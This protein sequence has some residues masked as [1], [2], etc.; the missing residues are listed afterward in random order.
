MALPEP[1]LMRARVVFELPAISVRTPDQDDAF[2]AAVQEEFPTLVARQMLPLG[3]PQNMPYLALQSTASRL[4]VSAVGSEM[5]TRF[6]G[7]WA[8]EPDRCLRYIRE[9][10]VATLGGWSALNLQPA[11]LGA[12]VTINFSMPDPPNAA[13][14]FIAEHHLRQ[15]VDPEALQDANMKVALKLNDSH[16]VSLGLA[17]YEQ[18]TF[19]RPVF[20]GQQ[21]I[22]VKAWEGEVEERGI[23]LTV[24]VNNKPDLITKQGEVVVDEAYAMSTI[25]LLARVIARAPSEFVDTA[26]LDIAALAAEGAS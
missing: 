8:T 10:V 21:L 22:Q 16:F 2:I 3:M 26:A 24:D 14:R 6:Y 7:D 25:D 20:P 15:E 17:N 13:A 9:K 4:A 11:L 5:E 18:R 12:I 23:E 1:M 19:E